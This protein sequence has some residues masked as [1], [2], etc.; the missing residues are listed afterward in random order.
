M[1]RPSTKTLSA[2]FGARQPVVAAAEI[3]ELVLQA[4]GQNVFVV[5]VRRRVLLGVGKPVTFLP[6]KMDFPVAGSWAST[7]AA[8]AW[9]TDD[10]IFF[11]LYSC[12]IH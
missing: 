1:T 9:H 5:V 2:E 10:T 12:R 6:S 4:E 3:L 8:G 11:L 7:S